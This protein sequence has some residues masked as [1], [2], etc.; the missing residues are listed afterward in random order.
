M[1]TP[2]ITG[3]PTSN[4]KSILLITI[5]LSEVFP[6]CLAILYQTEY[7]RSTT[8]NVVLKIFLDFLKKF[9]FF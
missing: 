8:K 5:I 6:F 4:S 7:N 1:Y 9:A 2:I 3:I